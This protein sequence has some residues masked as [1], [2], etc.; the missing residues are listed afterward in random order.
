MSILNPWPAILAR[1]TKAVQQAMVSYHRRKGHVLISDT[2][3]RDGEQMPRIH[4]SP[5]QKVRIA[6]ALEEAGVHSIDAGFAASSEREVSAIQA[7]A[8]AVKRP[9]LTSLARTLPADIDAA[10]RALAGRPPHKR[11]VSLLLGI[12]PIHRQDKLKKNKDQILSMI[13]ESVS[14]AAGKFNIVA[15][16]PEDASRTEPDFLCRAFEVAIDAGATTIGFADTVGFL[17]PEKCR[18]YIRRIQD[19][20][21]N[22]SKALLAVHYHNDLGLAVA[23]SLISVAEGANIVQGTIGGIGERAG[24]VPLEEV[25]LALQLHADQYR[26]KTSVDATKLLGLC[27]LVSELTGVPIAANK[28]ISGENIF[29]TE[30]GI[31]QDGLLKNPDTYMPYRPEVI[32][33]SGFRLVLGKHS[34]RKAVAH[35]LESLG[36]KLDDAGVEAVLK[37]IKELDDESQADRDEV[38]LGLVEK[39]RPG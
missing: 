13:A 8:R 9:V 27:R 16:G 30:S 4:L 36:V 32:G 11:G 19:G 10:D 34:G 29:A 37:Q 21:K 5:E 2:T 25:V 14:Y 26:K 22:Y 33:S 17:T 24:N 20:V 38:L 18:D 15:F 23:N 1:I 7:M 6:L 3:L 39:V 28:P 12:S 31:H 35:R